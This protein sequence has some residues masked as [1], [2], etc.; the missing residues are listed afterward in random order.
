[1][2]K[3]PKLTTL[4]LVS[5]QTS[6]RQGVIASLPLDFEEKGWWILKHQ[7]SKKRGSSNLY[8]CSKEHQ[9]EERKRESAQGKKSLEGLKKLYKPRMPCAWAHKRPH[10][11]MGAPLDCRVGAG[12]L[13]GFL[14][15][16]S[17]RPA[18][19]GRRH[20]LC[21]VPRLPARMIT[22]TRTG[23]N[24]SNA[25]QRTQLTILRQEQTKLK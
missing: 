12:S 15:S 24:D 25:L 2:L 19:A 4:T 5:I 9:R 17:A 20:H 13:A 1:M 14:N 18:S 3:L 21:P 16:L 10:S 22:L 6:R 23:Q 11:C 8:S 7:T